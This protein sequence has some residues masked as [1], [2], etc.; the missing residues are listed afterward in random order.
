MAKLLFT[1]ALT[2][3]I[4]ILSH[5]PASASSFGVDTAI[6]AHDAVPGDGVCETSTG[7]CSLRAAV[8]E[9][10]ALAGL[11]T[12]TVPVGT[13]LLT[14]PEIHNI[15]RAIQIYDDLVLTGAGAPQTIVS[16]EGDSPV[17]Y[18]N[19]LASGPPVVE[20]SG[21]TI[22][23]GNPGIWLQNGDLTVRQVSVRNNAEVVGAGILNS[24]DLTVIDSTISH[25]DAGSGY[26]GGIANQLFDSLTVVNSTVSNNSA[27]TVAG[28]Y[29][30]GSGPVSLTNL[31]IAD[32]NGDGL[33]LGSANT[34]LRNTLFAR[35]LT[36]CAGP[37][38]PIGAQNNLD[39]DGSCGL[40]GAGNI[41][42]VDPLLGPLGNN[43]GPTLTHRLIPGSPAIDAG[44]C[45]T[46]ADQR[47][48]S[49]PIDGD[50]SGTSECDI[51]AYEYALAVGGVVEIGRGVGEGGLSLSWAVLVATAASF[52][53]VLCVC[54]ALR[55]R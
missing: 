33:S 18:I 53:A 39:S 35:N 55:R 13:Y 31:T 37:V 34:T 6:D 11:D 32:N 22:R 7:D 54:S 5:H 48:V 19:D 36:D 28:I 3:F 51:G 15:S 9:A 1:F 2:A 25:N 46:V 49:R 8:E 17:L 23:E 16:A 24:G 42:N 12:V 21:L 27:Q 4:L 41:S 10:N 26:G 43:G 47:G 44:S 50:D 29:I 45:V 30:D 40:S 20:I 14:L 52:V 38:G